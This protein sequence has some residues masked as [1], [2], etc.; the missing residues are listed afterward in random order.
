[1]P[2]GQFLRLMASQPACFARGWPETLF[3]ALNCTT[4]LNKPMNL[5]MHVGHFG[6]DRILAI[7]PPRSRSRSRGAPD[8]AGHGPIEAAKQVEKKSDG[9]S[10]YPAPLGPWQPQWVL[11]LLDREFSVMWSNDPNPR[12]KKRACEWS[13]FDRWRSY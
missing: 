4:G 13:E 6:S 2:G 11:D 8:Q 12:E 7:M 5:Y 10:S 3:V 9:F 1:M